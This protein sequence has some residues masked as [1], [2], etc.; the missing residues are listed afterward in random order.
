MTQ[1]PTA[2]SLPPTNRL[3]AVLSALAIGAAS[4]G[5]VFGLREPAD[6]ERIAKPAH[7]ESK[8][9]TV[10]AVVPYRR[11]AAEHPRPNADWRNSLTSLKFETPDP[12]AT[13]IRTEELK[14]QS[15]ADRA[16]VR[17]FDG[18]PPMV[19]HPVD[20]QTDA[21]CLAC[22][23]QGAKI[24][25][26]IASRMSHQLLTNC[27]QCH[28]SSA[29]QPFATDREPP[30]SDFTGVY[31]AGSGQRAWTGAPPAIPHTTWMRENC[32]S[33]HG[34]VARAGLRTTHIWRTNCT[35]CHAPSAAL[36]QAAVGPPWATIP[37][38]HP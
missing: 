25:E 11:Q 38:T 4:L 2:N 37:A 9:R 6:P 1:H 23:A 29:T 33:C 10:P 32:A 24:G 27:T 31:R 12:F 15:L 8:P 20:Q 17:A 22:H 18:A 3:A 13:V 35:Q 21:N 19:P 34:L 16:A 30:E 28:V 7:Q 36:D 5:F 26:R 14:Q